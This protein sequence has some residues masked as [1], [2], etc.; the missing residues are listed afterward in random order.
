MSQFYTT[1]SVIWS[2]RDLLIII[3][4]N[5]NNNKSVWALYDTSSTYFYTQYYW[6]AEAQVVEKMQGYVQAI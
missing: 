1:V 6:I 2:M 3:D 5:N 4:N